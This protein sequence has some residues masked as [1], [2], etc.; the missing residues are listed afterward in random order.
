MISN[1][2]H[3]TFAF[4][5]FFANIDNFILLKYITQ[6]LTLLSLNVAYYMRQHLRHWYKAGQ[7]VIQAQL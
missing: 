7:Q 5:F 4:S 6:A 1:A 2:L 3:V